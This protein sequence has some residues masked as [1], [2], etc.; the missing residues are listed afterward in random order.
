VVALS[1][2]TSSGQ[3][4]D[5]FS[6][7]GKIREHFRVALGTYFLLP[8]WSAACRKFRSQIG[9]FVIKLLGTSSL[10]LLKT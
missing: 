7:L 1:K 8:H 9:R 4:R 2:S 6:D 3:L 10:K 5:V